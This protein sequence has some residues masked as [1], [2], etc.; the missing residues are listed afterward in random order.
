MLAVLVCAATAA[1]AASLG[2]I[3]SASLHAERQP[4]QRCTTS[5]DATSNGDPIDELQISGYPTEC[6]GATIHLTVQAA[7]GSPLAAGAVALGVE[8]TTVELD[9]SVAVA[10][11]AG[12]AA[13][14]SNLG[15]TV[16][17][18]PGTPPTSSTSWWLRNTLDGGDTTTQPAMP[19][20]TSSEPLS[21]GT[22]P[23][24]STDAHSLPGR[25]LTHTAGTNQ[26]ALWTTSPLAAPVTLSG[27]STLRLDVRRYQEGSGKANVTALLR[28]VD[29]NG[30]IVATLGQA[31]VETAAGN[32]G[33]NPPNEILNFTIPTSGSVP[34]GGRIELVVTTTSR[35]IRL[36]YDNTTYPAQLTLPAEISVADPDTDIVNNMLNVTHDWGE[37]WCAEVTVTVDVPWWVPWEVTIDLNHYPYDGE[38]YDVWEST[39]S[40]DADAGLLHAAGLGWNVLANDETPRVWGFCAMR[41]TPPVGGVNENFTITDDWGTGYCVDVV[42]STDSE[43]PIEWE[44]VID[45]SDAPINGVPYSVWNA[46]WSYDAVAKTLTATGVGWNSIIDHDTSAPWGFCANR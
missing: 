22:M 43:V 27:N 25:R 15:V 5:I 40:Y 39:W 21:G 3:D 34:A 33:S 18:T 24:Y 12:V 7:G 26:Q 37:G 14:I 31:S 28:A 23:N 19:I 20:T 46:T 4:A 2:G 45:M 8:P 1:S 41:L 29:S 9:S 36:Q 30:N 13:T 6:I 42:V 38:P 35:P 17:Y 32:P 16:T 44:I 10:S 11:I